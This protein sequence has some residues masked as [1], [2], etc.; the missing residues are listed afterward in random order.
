MNILTTQYNRAHRHL[1]YPFG[2][3]T[4]I[5]ASVS[6]FNCY[7]SL[8][9][10]WPSLPT[11]LRILRPLVPDLYAKVRNSSSIDTTMTKVLASIHIGDILPVVA[12]VLRNDFSQLSPL[13]ENLAY[14]T[15]NNQT[16]ETRKVTSRI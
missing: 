2:S 1:G 16:G 5:K 15:I 7:P 6:P 11:R 12:G 13:L 14:E 10:G 8:P 4:A 9:N 3:R